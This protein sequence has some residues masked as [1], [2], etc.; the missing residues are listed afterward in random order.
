M[1]VGVARYLGGRLAQQL[2]ADP[3]VQ[4]VIG[5]DVVEPT[6]NIGAAEFVR[7]DIRTSD[8]G[9]AIQ[10]TAPDTVVHMNI[11]AT[12]SD[13]GGRAPQKEI[14]VIG[15]MQLLAACQR[16][17]SVRK[18]VVK[19]STTVYGA[20]PHAPAL[21]S[22]DM[23]PGMVARGGYEKDAGEVEAYVRGYSRRRPDVGVTILRF[24]NV[25]GP[26]IRTA[27]SEYFVLPVVPVVL[28]RDPR[29]QLVHEQDCLDALRLATVEDRPGIFNVAGD[30]FLVLSQAL[31]R[32]GRPALPLPTLGTPLIGGVLRRTRVADMDAAMVRFLTHGRGV[33]TTRMRTALGFDPAYS[34]RA[35]FDAF[36]AAR[37]RG[38]LLERDRVRAV[39]QTLRG[40]LTGETGH[41]R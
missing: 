12:R 6:E 36:A 28:G 3:A 2:S 21:F 38:G 33:D 7:A 10:R 13:A 5:V 31:R 15:T 26:T 4:R 29:F 17:E 34:T 35:T 16:S 39:E 32:A 8:I 30:G 25:L 27:L 18:V 24:A 14:N 20:G 40:V 9:R 1:V 23:V 37:S 41:G 19:S 11:L 22:E